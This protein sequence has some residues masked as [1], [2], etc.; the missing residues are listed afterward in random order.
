MTLKQ[1]LNAEEKETL[2]AK[3]KSRFDTHQE[4]HESLSFEDIE[5]RLDDKKLVTLYNMEV[6]EGE[7]DVIVLDGE[8]HFV[9]CSKESPKGRRSVC[10]D[11]QALEARKKYKPDNSAVD[12]ANEIG[13]EILSEDDYRTLQEV[14][15]FDLKSSSWIV[16]PEKI[17]FL[18]GALFSDRRYDSIF[19]YHN[20]ADSYYGARGFR[21]KLK[22]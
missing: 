4:R 2:I 1:E 21:G 12:L 18:G 20:G 8:L 3:L 22:I 15:E 6:T 10:Y 5:S 16:T 13:I 17:R 14:G 11:R 7:P 9:D 19:V